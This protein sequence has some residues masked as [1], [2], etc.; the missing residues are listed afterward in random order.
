MV[1]LASDWMPEFLYPRE[2]NCQAFVARSPNKEAMLDV[3]LPPYNDDDGRGCT[4]YKR[5]ET[6]SQR[7]MRATTNDPTAPLAGGLRLPGRIVRLLLF[8]PRDRLHLGG[9]WSFVKIS[10][11][12]LDCEILDLNSSVAFVL[13]ISVSSHMQF[14]TLS[15]CTPLAS[16]PSH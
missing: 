7:T 3:L 16:C 1:H 2:G 10:G 6:S 11:D 8:R 15:M 9:Q 14:T 12:C 5:R 13:I 4:Y